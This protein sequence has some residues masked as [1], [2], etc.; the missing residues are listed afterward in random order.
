MDESLA[1]PLAA[2]FGQHYAEIYGHRPPEVGIEVVN[3]RAR[4]TRAQTA[5]GPMVPSRPADTAATSARQKR[6]PLYF[7]TT[8][9]FVD[10]DI[11]DRYALSPGDGGDGP[12]VVEECETSVVIGPDARFRVDEALNLIVDIDS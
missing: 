11:Y 7:Q 1:Q 12:A 3:L 10:G 9:G 4:L 6:R 5:T 2:R 8:G